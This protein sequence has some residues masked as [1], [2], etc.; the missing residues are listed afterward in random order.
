MPRHAD[1]YCSLLGMGTANTQLILPAHGVCVKLSPYLWMIY[2]CLHVGHTT[3]GNCRLNLF[4][5]TPRC[6]SI[7]LVITSPI[8]LEMLW[9][10]VR[11]LVEE[12]RGDNGERENEEKL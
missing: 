7:F 11:K 2:F 10:H 1:M 6:C 5:L 8:L 4:R 3:C 12:G 9:V